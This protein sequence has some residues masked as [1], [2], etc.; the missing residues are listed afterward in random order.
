[1]YS[2]YFFILLLCSFAMQA[3]PEKKIAWTKMHSEAANIINRLPETHPLRVAI[4][5]SR[6][7]ARD[8]YNRHENARAEMKYRLELRLNMVC[9]L[10]VSSKKNGVDFSTQAQMY[11][12]QWKAEDTL[13]S[14]RCE[15][16]RKDQQRL[17]ELQVQLSRLQAPVPMPKIKK[18]SESEREITDMDRQGAEN[19]L[20]FA[21]QSGMYVASSVQ[22][23]K[24]SSRQV[25]QSRAK[26]APADSC[27]DVITQKPS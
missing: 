21:Q 20:W 23:S 19:L 3:M 10:V 17:T 2:M 7:R 8:I 11:N 26:K 27:I 24:A 15:Q 18:N 4:K 22:V 16:F 1:M 12:Q 14:D 6:I 13:L 5:E 25:K 9:S